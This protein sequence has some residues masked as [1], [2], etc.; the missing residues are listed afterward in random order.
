FVEANALDRFLGPEA[1]VRLRPCLEVAHFDLGE[2]AALAG[3]DKLA[4]EDDPEP[5]SVLQDIAWLDVN[6]VDLHGQAFSNRRA[7]LAGQAQGR[8]RGADELVASRSFGGAARGARDARS[9]RGRGA[10]ILPRAR[11]R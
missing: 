4:L 9:D 6:G 5:P 7:S 2:G 1:L 3:L 11:L 10:P 8:K